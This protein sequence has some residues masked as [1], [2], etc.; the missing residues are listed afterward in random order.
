[1]S[2]DGMEPRPSIQKA[3]EFCEAEGKVGT[4]TAVRDAGAHVAWTLGTSQVESGGW[5][6]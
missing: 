1:M 5:S 3:I 6:M 4:S 2:V